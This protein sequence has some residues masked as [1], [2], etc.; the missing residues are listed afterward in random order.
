[1]KQTYMY[2]WYPLFQAQ[3]DNINIRGTIFITNRIGVVMACVLASSV[4]DLDLESRSDE[5]PKTIK[6]TF[7]ASYAKHISSMSRSKCSKLECSE[8]LYQ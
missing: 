8:L 1:M 5:N 6:D 2:L 3:S 4:V 7:A